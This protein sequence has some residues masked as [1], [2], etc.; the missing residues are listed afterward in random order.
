MIEELQKILKYTF[1]VVPIVAGFD[2]FLNLLTDWHL[3]MSPFLAKLLPFEPS[4]FMLIVGVI[5]IVAGLIVFFKTEFG[6]YIVATWLTAISLSFIF[7]GHYLDLAVRDLVMAIAAYTLAKL[8]SKTIIHEG[9]HF[10]NFLKEKEK[11]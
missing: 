9:A 7:S 2:K 6:A 5:E 8:S 4:T 1:V 10:S 3:Y 11:R